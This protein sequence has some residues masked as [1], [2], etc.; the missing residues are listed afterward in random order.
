MPLFWQFNARRQIQ[1]LASNPNFLPRREYLNNSL[2]RKS[3]LNIAKTWA[4]CLK[5]KSRILWNFVCFCCQNIFQNFT[6]KLK[7]EVNLWFFK[8]K[9]PF[10]TRRI[11]G[12]ESSSDYRKF[13]TKG[14]SFQKKLRGSNRQKDD[15]HRPLGRK[16]FILLKLL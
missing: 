12:P 16:F 6:W 3:R 8:D 4:S 5:S 13:Y 11:N 2:W 9:M 14:K 10:D 15:Q 1:S 7:S